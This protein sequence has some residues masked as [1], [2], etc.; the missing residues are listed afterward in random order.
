MMR[1]AVTHF[2]LNTVL[3]PLFFAATTV[4]DQ[5]ATAA[6]DRL[7][8]AYSHL[9]RDDP[10][11]FPLKVK[12]VAGSRSS[13]WRG[14]KVLYYDWCR[15]NAPQWMQDRPAYVVQHGDPHLGNIGTY[16]SRGRL[17]RLGFGLVDYDDTHRAPFQY[18]LLQGAVLL[19][20]TAADAKLELDEQEWRDLID[21]L[22]DRY[23]DAAAS[24]RNTQRLLRRSSLVRGMM[25]DAR[26]ADYRDELAELTGGSGKFARTLGSRRELKSI[27]LPVDEERK[28]AVAD[29]LAE[30]ILRT[31][32]V[33]RVFRFK[34][35]REVRAAVK[36]VAQ[37]IH[38]TSSGSQGLKKYLVLLD[39]PLSESRRRDVVLY[40]K[41]EVASCAERAG[42][43]ERDPRPAA[44]RCA[45]DAGA[46][47]SPSRYVSG[48]FSMG[49]ESYWVSLREPWGDELDPADVKALDDL[50]EYADLWAAVV[51]ASHRRQD[52]AGVMKARMTPGLR[53]E[54]LK[55]SAA[56][57]EQLT[58]DYES[59]GDD[60]QVKECVD[61]VEQAIA[62]YRPTPTTRQATRKSSKP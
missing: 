5:P 26:D 2:A 15:I 41:Q 50:H 47:T 60:P 43:V 52:A 57:V 6:F 16:A 61:K 33:R 44:Q 12:F 46:L 48:W 42:L 14:G 4:A 54:L 22:L 25:R 39:R 27:L 31:P 18:E 53:D 13:L 28:R 1:P 34:Q 59:L 35:A 36:D 40:L 56:Y 20:L 17:G 7:H 62:P 51:G 55:L 11:S 32:D 30:A 3:L 8:N 37:R 19:R 49:E 29:G 38:L 58:R 9:S 45:E 10:F 24:D 23:L 21:A